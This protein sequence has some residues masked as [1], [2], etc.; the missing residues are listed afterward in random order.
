MSPVFLF[1]LSCFLYKY[2]IPFLPKLITYFIRLI[3]SCYI[4]YSFKAGKNLVLGYGGLGIVIHAKAVVGDNCHTDQNVTIGGTSKKVKVPVLGNNVYIGA[5]AIIIGPIKI[6][7]DVVI[8]ANAV[9]IND[10]PDNSLVVGV[11][12]RIAKRGIRK[13]DYI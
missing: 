10:I 4:P 12:G 11:P 8:G 5:G 2:R 1:R 9:V 7:N 3:F 13:E 6:G